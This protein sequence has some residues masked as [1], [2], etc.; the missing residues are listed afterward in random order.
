VNAVLLHAR[1]LT[2]ATAD[3][4]IERITFT[5][6]SI[7]PSKLRMILDLIYISPEP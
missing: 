5:C 1:T 7:L 6:A 2:E 3:V 4:H